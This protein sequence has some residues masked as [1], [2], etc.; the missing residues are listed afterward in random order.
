MTR[1]PGIV[2]T[3]EL[4]AYMDSLLPA[5]EPV[6]ARLEREMVESPV[7]GIGPAVGQLLRLLTRAAG[8]RNAIELGTAVGYSAIWLAGGCS[9]TVFTLEF[10]SERAAQ[11]RR[12]LQEAGLEERVQVIEEDAIAFLER[13]GEPVDCIFN[14]LLTSFPDERTVDR[15]FE[16]CL[17]RLRPKGLLLADNALRRGEVLE[18]RSQPARN[19]ARWNHLVAGEPRLESMILP[20]RDGVSIALRRD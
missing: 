17:R 5:R 3:P 14:D 4:E 6:L 19:V 15:C 2:L 13:D 10:D 12:H 16:L 1:L 18:P 11:A 7:P 20:L 8:C 9:G